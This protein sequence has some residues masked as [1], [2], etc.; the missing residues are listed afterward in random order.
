MGEFMP[1]KNEILG[2]QLSRNTPKSGHGPGLVAAPPAEGN[3]L[4]SVS[5]LALAANGHAVAVDSWRSAVKTTKLV[6]QAPFTRYNQLS[7]RFDNRLYRV[8]SRLSNRLY[9]PVVTG[10]TTRFDNRFWMFVY[11]NTIQPVGNPVM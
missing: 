5:L 6:R 2:T 11:T 7:N 8:Y 4:Y 1:P 9:N 10:C 3:S